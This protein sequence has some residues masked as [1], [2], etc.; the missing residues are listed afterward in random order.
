MPDTGGRYY[1]VS[2]L[3]M[4]TEVFS[5]IGSRTMGTRAGHFAHVAPGWHGKLPPDV[6]RIEAPTVMIWMM[7]RIQTNVLRT[8]RTSISFRMSEALPCSASGCNIL[9]KK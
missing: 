2:T 3:D 4:G 1:L 5:S 7:A 9:Q 6:T 8:M